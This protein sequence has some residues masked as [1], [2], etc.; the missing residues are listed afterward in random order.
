MSKLTGL[1]STVRTD[2]PRLPARIILHATEKWG[3][4]SWAAFAPGAVFLMSRGENGLLTLID[5]GLVPPTPHLPEIKSWGDAKQAVHALIREAHDFKTAVFD[6]ANGFSRLCEEAV[7]ERDYRSSWFEF[8]SYGSGAQTAAADWSEFLDV[9]DE[10]RI[11][12]R[13]A[14]IL[15]GH[16]SIKN[17]KNPEGPDYD[18][19]VPEMPKPIWS[20]THKWADAI[21][22]GGYLIQTV[23]EKDQAKENAK[24][25]GGDRRVIH[26]ERSASFDAGNRFDLPSILHCGDDPKLAF[27]VFAKA[28]GAAKPASPPAVPAQGNPP[29][30]PPAASSPPPPAEPPAPPVDE[31]P[32][33]DDGGYTDDPSADEGPA[34]VPTPAIVNGIIVNIPDELHD[35]LPMIKDEDFLAE[36]QR[37]KISLTSAPH[38]KA[39]SKVLGRAI[40][41]NTTV[42]KFNLRDKYEIIRDVRANA[43]R[44]A[45]QQAAKKQA[46]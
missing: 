31:A 41:P 24:V 8:N 35:D 44:K 19:V 28:M 33:Y 17:F 46:A 45:A 36:M 22:Y 13:M 9:L 29:P 23:K 4:S 14:I 39:I 20:V 38:C 16:S 42:D 1:L 26:T 15:L 40:E 21:L 10:L 5:R 7:C 43:A 2:A 3:K 37:F 11:K 34:P 12:R 30:A 27:G 32:E 18:R 6:V 25:K